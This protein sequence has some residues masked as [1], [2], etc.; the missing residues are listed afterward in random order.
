MSDATPAA[1]PLV[2]QK[3]LRLVL[4]LLFGGVFFLAG[5][6]KVRDPQLFTMQVR[7]FEMLPDPWNAALALAL[8]WMEIL[9]GLA[10]ITGDLRRGAL[11]L[12]N[13]TLVVFLAVLGW[14]ISTG[15]QVDCGC[16]GT[17]LQLKMPV[18]FGMDAVLFLIGC[19]LWWRK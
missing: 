17:A 18:E 4:S 11:V 6:L 5:S 16:F 2:L 3:R 15:K 12:L 7:S 19:W 9:C 8:P 1:G 14:T 10:V 13:G